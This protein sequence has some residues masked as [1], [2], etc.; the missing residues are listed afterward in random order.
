[1]LTGRRTTEV[2]DYNVID[3]L[4]YNF[5]RAGSSNSAITQHKQTKKPKKKET[6]EEL[7]LLT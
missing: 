7:L 2:A 6:K 4:Y 3:V 5:S 1:M